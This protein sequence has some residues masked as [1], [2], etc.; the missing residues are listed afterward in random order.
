MH[1]R[2]VT[3]GALMIAGSNQFSG[4]SSRVLEL[5]TSA[6]TAMIACKYEHGVVYGYVDLLSKWS[7]LLRSGDPLQ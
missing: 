3:T 5:A 2:L 6:N 7:L 1:N 4:N